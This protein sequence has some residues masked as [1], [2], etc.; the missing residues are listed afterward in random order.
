ML[1]GREDLSHY[2]DLVDAV[3]DRLQAGGKPWI[4][5]N[6]PGAVWAARSDNRLSGAMFGLRSYRHRLFESSVPLY[7]PGLTARR[8]RVNRERTVASIG[9]K[10][11]S[12]SLG[13]WACG[14]GA[15]GDGG[16]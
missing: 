11:F 14:K 12:R 16:D 5:E 15:R 2:P 3:R 7:R 8:W 4:I 1:G 9:I 10:G 13:M 6:V